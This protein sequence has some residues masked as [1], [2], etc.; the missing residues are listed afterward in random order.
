MAKKLVFTQKNKTISYG[1]FLCKD[2]CIVYKIVR[3]PE[4]NLFLEYKEEDR[5][6]VV[7]CNKTVSASEVEA[8]VKNN[9]EWVLNQF[10]KIDNP[11]PWLILG[12]HIPVKTVIGNQH[13]VEYENNQITVYIKYKKQYRDTARAFLKEMATAYLNK[14]VN[15]LLDQLGFKASGI[16]VKWFGSTWG[17]CWYSKQLDFN[18]SL[19]QY[20][21]R[22]IDSV[23]YHEIAHFT[24]MNHSKKFHDLLETYN[25]NHREIKNEMIKFS[26]QNHLW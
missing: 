24:H 10:R 8:Y 12:K 9:Y 15:E 3:K 23:I 16:N 14:R 11:D 2:G 26:W 18:A 7:T 17:R 6:F 21:P 22:F 25:P 20:E 19:I 13:K 1:S 5:S 4:A